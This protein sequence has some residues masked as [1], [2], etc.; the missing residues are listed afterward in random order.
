MVAGNAQTSLSCALPQSKCRLSSVSLLVRVP[1]SSGGAALPWDPVPGRHSLHIVA[2]DA[3]PGLSPLEATALLAGSRPP[4]TPVPLPTPVPRPLQGSRHTLSPGGRMVAL[5]TLGHPSPVPRAAYK[6]VPN[7]VL[8]AGG[9]QQQHCVCPPPSQ[10]PA[11]GSWQSHRPGGLS[12]V[13][14]GSQRG[15]PLGQSRGR[16]RI[17]RVGPTAAVRPGLGLRLCVPSWCASGW[18]SP[19]WASLSP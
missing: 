5:R 3:A 2:E 12:T 8:T 16:W 4:P 7:A 18:P 17:R 10:P 11:R 14:T 13:V 9:D 15:E 19:P 6:V 1:T